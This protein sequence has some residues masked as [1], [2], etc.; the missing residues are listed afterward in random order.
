MNTF[1][2]EAPRVFVTTYGLYNEGKQFFND[3]TGFWIDCAEY[4]ESEIIENFEQQGDQDP[5]IMFTDYENFPED[6]YCES[7]IDFDLI[8][9]YEALDENE[10]ELLTIVM[11]HV[12]PDFNEALENLDKFYLFDGKK[13]D[14]A[15]EH[16]HDCYEV[17]EYLQNYIDYDQYA[18]DL[19]I[20][21]HIIEI[22]YNQTLVNYGA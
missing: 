21:G 12:L 4:D 5:E 7:G 16:I 2:S 6:L 9:Q 17:P 18:R 3:K 13:S 1:D 14:Y 11:D 10:K 15:A 22:S 20:D 19:E 8:A